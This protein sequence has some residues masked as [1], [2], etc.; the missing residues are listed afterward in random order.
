MEEGML[1]LDENTHKVIS[2]L[3]L[4]HKCSYE[5]HAM[6]KLCQFRLISMRKYGVSEK[7]VETMLKRR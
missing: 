5:E 4:N 2:V 6:L 3:I 1:V 7:I